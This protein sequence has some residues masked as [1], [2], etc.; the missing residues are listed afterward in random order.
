MR[1]TGGLAKKERERIFRLFLERHELRFAEIEDGTK[2]RSSL[3][4][5]H[6]GALAKEGLLRKEDDQYLL[7]PKGERYIPLLPHVLGEELSPL[8]VVLVAV[9]SKKGILL[10]RRKRRPYQGRWSLIGGK[11][12]L[13]EN[14]KEASLRLIREKAGICGTFLGVHGVLHERIRN[15][16]EVTCSFLLFL[17]SVEASGDAEGC[18]WFALKSLPAGLIPSDRWLLE[19][20][21][22]SVLEVPSDTIREEGGRIV[23]FEILHGAEEK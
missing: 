9:R 17:A 1:Y 3:L 14:L 23:D 12:L 8:P 11:L 21:L 6:L 7:T 13:E 22:G 20:R 18:K 19:H 5:Y 15:G 2:I 16:D 4:A 10:S